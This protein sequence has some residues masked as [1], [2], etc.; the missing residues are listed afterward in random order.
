MVTIN[1]FLNNDEIDEED[2]TEGFLCRQRHTCKFFLKYKEYVTNFRKTTT[3]LI[4]VESG[5]IVIFRQDLVHQACGYKIANFS[6]FM[7]LNLIGF[8]R[9]PDITTKVKLR[10]RNKLNLDKSGSK[11]KFLKNLILKNKCFSYILVITNKISITVNFL[12]IL[13]FIIQCGQID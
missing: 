5:W 7:Y 6:Y 4:T 11:D 8:A 13:L 12:V 1:Y 9:K 10:N 3:E 2:R